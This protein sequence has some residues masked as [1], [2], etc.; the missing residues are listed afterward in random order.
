MNKCDI[1]KNKSHNNENIN[2]CGKKRI[3]TNMLTKT[4]TRIT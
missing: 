4:I 3:N 2:K 1:N